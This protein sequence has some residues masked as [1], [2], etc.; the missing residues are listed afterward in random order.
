MKKTLIY[1]FIF[2]TLGAT[3][4]FNMFKNSKDKVLDAFKESSNYYVLQ[5]GVYSNEKIMEEN[6]KNLSSKVIEEENGK[7]YV[8]VG[9]TTKKE[10]AM[11][12]KKIYESK[13]YQLYLKNLKIASEEFYNNTVQFDMLINKTAKEDEILTIEEVVLANYDE[14]IKNSK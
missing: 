3:F 6:I 5:E 7:Y 9:I 10:N 2:T 12:L 13:G 14:I 8:Y 1:G 4:G 11:K